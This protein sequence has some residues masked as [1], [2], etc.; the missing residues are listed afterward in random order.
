MATEIVVVGGGYAGIAA[1]QRLGKHFKKNE[2]V[3]ITIIDK[4]PFKTYMT[5]LHEV[6]GGRVDESAIRYDLRRLFHKYKNISIVTDTVTDINHETKQVIANEHTLKYDYLVLGMGGEPND[7]GVPGVKEHGHTL[8]SY[9]DAV[10]LRRHIIEAVEAA[11]AEPDI[12]KRRELLSFVVI[13]AGFTGVEM[14]GE[15]IEW[16]DR[17]AKDNQLDRSEFSVYL[18]E[19]AAN[20][21]QMVTEKEREKATKYMEKKGIQISLGD[22]IVRL[23]E[24]GVELASGRVIPTRTAIWT[25]GVKANSEAADF[26]MQQGRAGRL[27]ADEYMESVD[28]PNVY[29]VGDLVYYED[30]NHDNMPTPQIV[31]A[32][33]ATGKTAADNIIATIEG[34][35]KKPYDGKY[36]GFMVSIGGKYAVAYVYDKYHVSGW[37]ANIM[38]HGGNILYFLGIGSLFYMIRYIRNEFF[39]IKDRRN[40][41]GGALAQYGNVLWSVPLRL[42]Y[43]SMWLYEGLK[44]TF[45][46]FGSTSWLGDQVVF[47]FDWLQ[48]P[49]SGATEAMSSAS[50]AGEAGWSEQVFSLNYAYGEEPMQVIK[51][52]PNWFASIM[53]VMMPNQEVALFMQK[54]MTFVEIAIGLALI[55][56]LFVW[57]TSAVTVALVVMFVL[58]GM[59]FWVNMWFIPVAIALMNGAGRSFGLDYYVMPWL[60]RKL[61]PMLYGKVS[62]RYDDLAN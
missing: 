57:L 16:V 47:P 34:T 3:H 35:E 28:Y 7:F 14:V 23:N 1:A 19:A 12:N 6:A 42:F 33:E 9:E 44:K 22:G 25:A 49:T 2:Q 27:M 43:G 24:D 38:K 54:M 40:A 30:P 53:K 52:M 36:D 60:A 4:R 58:S 10:S 20:I 8:W 45:G 18:V 46:W 26:G 37:F 55:V 29:V 50:Q 11:A 21:L 59:F 13:G 32:A 41:F 48:D 15:I 62:H 17:L 51:E 56:G 5:E 61:D 39:T 31:Q